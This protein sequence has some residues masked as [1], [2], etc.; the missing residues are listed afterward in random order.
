M[1]PPVMTAFSKTTW[2][3]RGISIRDIESPLRWYSR[4]LRWTNER[5]VRM[6]HFPVATTAQIRGGVSAMKQ[7]RNISKSQLFHIH[8]ELLTHLGEREREIEIDACAGVGLNR[9]CVNHGGGVRKLIVCGLE[10]GWGS[11][12]WLIS[13]A[14]GRSDGDLVVKQ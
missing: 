5:Y 3:P 6:R 7:I 4:P 8:L 14:V 12:I 10:L 9:E 2:I 13:A 11:L 1:L